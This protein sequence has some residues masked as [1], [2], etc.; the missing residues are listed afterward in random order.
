MVVVAAAAAAVA[1]EVVVVVVVM[2]EE[3]KE[4]E[5]ILNELLVFGTYRLIN[6]KIVAYDTEKTVLH[7]TTYVATCCD[8]LYDYPQSTHTQKTKITLHI[9]FSI[10]LQSLYVVQCI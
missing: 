5:N 1:A 6:H 3:E 2:Q 7:Y 10:R 4:K 9:S 8:Q